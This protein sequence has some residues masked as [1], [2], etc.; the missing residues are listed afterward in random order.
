M[1][2]ESTQDISR[3]KAIEMLGGILLTT[4][5]KLHSMTDEE[6]EEMLYSLTR[7]THKFDNWQ[8]V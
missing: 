7:E 3:E 1:S 6:L 4:I 8:I 2:I 5:G